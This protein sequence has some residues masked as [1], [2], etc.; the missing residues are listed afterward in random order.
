MQKN[1]IRD[2]AILGLYLVIVACGKKETPIRVGI[3]HSRSDPIALD[4]KSVLDAFSLA[5]DEVNSQSGLLGKK[6]VAISVVGESGQ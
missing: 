2:V 1:K 3:V 4:E 6:I 5:I